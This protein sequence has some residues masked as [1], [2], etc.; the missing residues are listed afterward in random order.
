MMSIISPNINPVI[1]SCGPLAI[2]WYSLSYITSILLGWFVA[3]WLVKK[4]AL[5]ISTQHLENFVS[6]AIFGIVIGGRAG[7]VVFYDP[8][9]Y[10][11]NPIEILKIYQGGM[12]F[13]GGIIGLGLSAYL[14][15]RQHKIK[16]LNLVDVI[17]IVGPIGLC[18]GRIANFINQ[19]LAGRVTA[20]KWGVIFPLIDQQVRHP[21]QIYEAFFE[22]L[23]LLVVLIHLAHKYQILSY[24]GLTTG[25][26]LIIYSLFR[27]VIETFREPDVQIGFILQ[28]VTMGQ[29]LSVPMLIFG[30]Y[31]AVT[32]KKNF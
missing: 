29:L 13:H 31:I 8:V 6:W 32:A 27:I 9:T 14:F 12:S 17:S 30:T 20:V 23:V 28:N 2:T 16:F 24:S 3:N 4:F 22:G 7:Y 11:S 19:E 15:S 26:F 21:S 10:L 18:L 5:S 1:I 25:I